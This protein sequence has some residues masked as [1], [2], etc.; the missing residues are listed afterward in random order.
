MQIGVVS[1]GERSSSLLMEI[2]P[3]AGYCNEDR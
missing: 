1:V 3:T 2:K